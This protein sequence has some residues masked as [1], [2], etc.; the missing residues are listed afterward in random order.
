MFMTEQYLLTLILNKGQVI[1]LQYIQI[2]SK[3]CLSCEAHIIH[4]DI[5]VEPVQVTCF[6][7]LREKRTSDSSSSKLRFNPFLTGKQQQQRNKMTKRIL[8]LTV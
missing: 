8:T 6:K 2:T 4:G 3:R 5:F 7:Q 1:L